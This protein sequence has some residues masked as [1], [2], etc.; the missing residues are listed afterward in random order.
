MYAKTQS[1]VTF[2]RYYALYQSRAEVGYPNHEAG[3]KRGIQSRMEEEKEFRS[4]HKPHGRHHIGCATVRLSRMSPSKQTTSEKGSKG[5]W[6]PMAWYAGPR[7]SYLS[8]S[9]PAFYVLLIITPSD[10]NSIG[11]CPRWGH[12]L[13]ES[14]PL[15]FP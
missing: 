12:R 5:T 7:C 8:P 9:G 10:L 3:P 13:K 11:P 14:Y 2:S 1:G 4:D 15:T 6:R